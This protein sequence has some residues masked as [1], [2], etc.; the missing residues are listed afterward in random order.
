MS[1]GATSHSRLSLPQLSVSAS[2][3]SLVFSP[4][5]FSLP[6]SASG[7]H[8]KSP[9]PAL[10]HD[11]YP[12][13]KP[14]NKSSQRSLKSLKPQ[15]QTNLLSCFCCFVL[16]FRLAMKSSQPFFLHMRCE[17]YVRAVS[18][19]PLGKPLQTTRSLLAHM[20]LLCHQSGIV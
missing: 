9:T 4:S 11:T 12:C 14:I 17:R 8:E 19:F 3:S 15:T 13:L 10:S 18:R 5:L 1:E 16:F 6:P 2:L 7:H 20:A